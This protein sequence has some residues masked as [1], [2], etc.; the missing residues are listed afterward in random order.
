MAKCI[1]GKA[2]FH[3]PMLPEVL[4]INF[5]QAISRMWRHAHTPSPNSDLTMVYRV[6]KEVI[7]NIIM[8]LPYCCSHGRRGLGCPEKSLK[9]FNVGGLQYLPDLALEE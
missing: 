4:L 1:L 8:L 2:K 9:S 5:V 6:L 3:E 7:C